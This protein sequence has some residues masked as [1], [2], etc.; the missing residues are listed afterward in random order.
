MTRYVPTYELYGETSGKEPDF[1]LHC[2]TIPSR[3]SL[4]QWRG[5][6]VIGIQVTQLKHGHRQVVIPEA[7]A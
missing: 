7:F 3:S 5:Q 4:H 1:W 6:G 2:E